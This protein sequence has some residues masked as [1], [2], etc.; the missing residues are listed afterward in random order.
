MK[1]VGDLPKDE[2]KHIAEAAETSIGAP[3]DELD[4]LVVK[5]CVDQIRSLQHLREQIAEYV[6]GLMS[7]IAPNL[8]AL[9]GGTIGARLISLAGGL[10]SLSRFP[11]STIQV[12]GAEKALFRSFKTKAKPPKH[13][14]IYQH[15]S[16]R[17]APKRY[18]GKIARA[19]AG[20]I[21][22]AARVD[23]MA[24]EYVGEKLAS[25]FRIRV[26][27]ILRH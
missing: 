4:I 25:E 21:A 15:P 11:A 7:Q 19:L 12:L 6:E 18:R 2:A 8:K 3:F 27:E 20:K 24:G 14:V 26:S 13:G 16:I 9:V 23:S 22:I 10:S 1:A 5:R 17:T